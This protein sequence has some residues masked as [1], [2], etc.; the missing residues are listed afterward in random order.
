[1]AWVDERFCIDRYESV[2]EE[3]QAGTWRAAS[4]FET[5]DDR[6]IRAVP[7]AGVI[8]QAYISGDEAE[9]ACGA[10]GKRLCTSTEW[11]QACQGPQGRTWPYGD[12]HQPG[13]CNDSYGGGH[14]VT[15]YF[16]TSDGVWDQTHMN[17]PGINQQQGTVAPGGTYE[18]CVSDWGVYDLH[19]NLHEW[20][21]EADGTFRGGFYAD[22]SINGAGCTYQTTAHAR[23]YHDYS[24]GFRCCADLD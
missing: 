8:P 4:P 7:A 21:A 13:T 3:G 17:D 20:V 14:P 10:S 19:G 12:S 23:S 11:L 6:T 1:M 22:A 18:R 2:L 9:R 15:D 16:G 24:T 5:V